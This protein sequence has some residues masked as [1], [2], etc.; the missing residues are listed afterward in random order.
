MNFG[1][2]IS[3]KTQQKQFLTQNHNFQTKTAK[4]VLVYLC[5][6]RKKKTQ[7]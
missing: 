3:N 2:I 6:K 4:Y 5:Q 7:N 1:S